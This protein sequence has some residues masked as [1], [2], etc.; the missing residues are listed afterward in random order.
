MIGD[1][2]IGKKVIARG[3]ASGVYYGTLIAREGQEVELADA[4][5]IWYWEGAASV[6]QIAVDG[7]VGVQNIQDSK[8]TMPVESIVLTDIIEIIACSEE[9]IARINSVPVWRI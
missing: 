2:L 9:S 7:I 6:M 3:S 1:N 4:R 5:N 8:I